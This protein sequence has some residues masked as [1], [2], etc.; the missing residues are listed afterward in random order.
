MARR[1]SA[2]AA[3]MRLDLG[4]GIRELPN[5]ACVDA[6]AAENDRR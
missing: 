1:F 5:E 3:E 4:R 6:A 2:V